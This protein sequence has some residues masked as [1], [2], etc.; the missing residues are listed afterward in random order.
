MQKQRPYH[1]DHLFLFIRSFP[2]AKAKATREAARPEY[3]RPSFA[4]LPLGAK[5]R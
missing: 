4:N 3:T 2:K 1:H 5:L